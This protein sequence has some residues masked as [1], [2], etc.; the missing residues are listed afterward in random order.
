MPAVIQRFPATTNNPDVVLLSGTIVTNSTTPTVKRG[1]GFTVSKPGTGLYRVTWSTP[2]V[3]IGGGA[4]LVKVAN[5]EARWLS[6]EVYV[7]TNN[8]MDFRGEDS[9]GNLANL[10]NTDEIEFT[11]AIQTKRSLPK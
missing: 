1:K 4:I 6:A 8:Y 5:G 3:K 11:L 9:S 7:A 2:G 10:A